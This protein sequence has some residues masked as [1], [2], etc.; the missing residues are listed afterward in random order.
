MEDDIII[1]NFN[2]HDF[3][4]KEWYI[5]N[6]IL[7]YIKNNLKLSIN[8]NYVI[9]I[10]ENIIPKHIFNNNI[11]TI[12]I[13]EFQE[14][15]NKNLDV[16]YKEKSIYISNTKQYTNESL[17]YCILLGVGYSLLYSQ[18]DYLFKDN[19]IQIEFLKKRV[20][21]SNI[22]KYYVEKGILEYEKLISIDYYRMLESVVVHLLESLPRDKNILNALNEIYITNF[23]MFSIE[24]YVI[25]GYVELLYTKDL[26]KFKRVY[27]E[28]FLKL[29]KLIYDLPGKTKG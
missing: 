6:K 16:I 9:E 18:K 1:E 17:I 29:D 5:Y 4:K 28:L 15:K 22:L 23:G 20:Q 27:P 13:G 21:L 8:M 10:I 3:N 12:F 26:S 19:I 7:I 14:L 24:N 2:M 11:D 25:D